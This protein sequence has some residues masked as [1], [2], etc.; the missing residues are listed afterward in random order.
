MIWFSCVEPGLGDTTGDAGICFPP[1]LASP[2]LTSS[3]VID[4][5]S[6]S[7]SWEVE[8]SF[9]PVSVALLE[10]LVSCSTVCEKK[11]RLKTVLYLLVHRSSISRTSLI[12][13]QPYIV[14]VIPLQ[15]IAHSTFA[16]S[17]S[18]L[19]LTRFIQKYINV[20]NIRSVSLNFT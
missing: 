20:Y 16:L 3:T 15:I 2:F 19:A 11:M 14:E 5:S 7:G 12:W 18:Y 10:P 6:P 8:V 9:V 4:S 13:N 1:S 17:Q